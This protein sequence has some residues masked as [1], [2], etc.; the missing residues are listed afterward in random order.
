MKEPTIGHDAGCPAE[1]RVPFGQ[2]D[3]QIDFIFDYV[4]LDSFLRFDS[5]MRKSINLNEIDNFE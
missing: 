5:E 1:T 3:E 2:I 4:I